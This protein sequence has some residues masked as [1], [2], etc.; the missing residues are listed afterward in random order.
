M[1]CNVDY[2]VR[3]V[4][5]YPLVERLLKILTFNVKKTIVPFIIVIVP[6]GFILIYGLKKSC[7]N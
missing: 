2:I 5:Y 6:L 4:D 3:K 7:S 1:Y